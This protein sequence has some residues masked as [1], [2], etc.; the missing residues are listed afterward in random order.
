MREGELKT[1]KKFSDVELLDA[2]KTNHEL[3]KAL[4]YIYDNYY[5]MLTTVVLN[6]NGNEA[7]A[8][9]IIQEVLVAFIDLVRKDAYR[10]EASVKSFLYTLTKNLWYTEAKRRDNALKRAHYFEHQ[11]DT[12]EKD[13]SNRLVRQ[14]SLLFISDLFDQLGTICKK[15]LTLFYYE[16]LSMKEILRQ[17]DFENEQVLRNKKYKCQ[18]ELIKRVE[19]SPKLSDNLKNAL[20]NG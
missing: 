4:D 16:N 8:E 10:G 11:K 3:N 6:N 12:L 15:I 13:V 18:K 19:V 2:I 17:V 5:Y 9:D 1:R 20:Q 14:E 7:D